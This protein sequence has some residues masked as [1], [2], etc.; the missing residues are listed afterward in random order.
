[1]FNDGGSSDRSIS[2]KRQALRN[3]INTIEDE[4]AL[5]ENNLAFFGKSKNA[6]KLIAEFSVKIEKAQQKLEKLRRQ[7]SIFNKIEE[8]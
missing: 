5:L 6:Q 7:Y 3:K 8:E 1:M 2:N 4:I